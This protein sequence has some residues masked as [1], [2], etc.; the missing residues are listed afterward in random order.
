MSSRPPPPPSEYP[1]SDS[2][3]TRKLAKLPSE[4][5]FVSIDEAMSLLSCSRSYIYTLRKQ[6]LLDS[7]R[8]SRLTRITVASIERFLSGLSA[9]R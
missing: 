5:E 6:G 3:V 2:Q 9:A 8:M 1:Q 4:K 7:V